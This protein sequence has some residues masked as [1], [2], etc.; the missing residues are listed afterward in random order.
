M[1]ARRGVLGMLA[2]GA[3]SLLSGCGLFGGNSYR[4]RMTVEVET[5]KGPKSGSSVMEVVSEKSSIRVG[6]QTASGIGLRGEAVVVETAD[7][8]LFV[9]LKQP[10]GEGPLER[11]VTVALAPDAEKGMHDA[12]SDLGGWLGG[13]KAELPRKE[14][15]MMVRF[16]DLSDPKSVVK[17][18]PDAAGVKRILV[19]TTSD[20]LSSGIEK[21]LAW[22]QLQV[23]SLGK[24]PKGLPI[25]ELPEEQRL[26][27]RAFSTELR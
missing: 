4:F 1:M 7:G 9:L 21:R 18:D 19:E 23:G 16:R 13:V 14:W 6:D 22:L 25:G 24:R 20:V 17:V 2:G 5:P 3:A 11:S 27:V 12:V 10:D 8:P 26:T 15:P